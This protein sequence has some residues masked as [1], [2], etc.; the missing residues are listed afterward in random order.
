MDMTIFRNLCILAAC[1]V[2]SA[3]DQPSR[4]A[5][6][7]LP[8]E[9][10]AAPESDL[11]V[12]VSFNE[13]IQPLLSEYCYH[14]H[15]PDSGTRE[16]KDHPLRLDRPEDAFVLR[17]NGLPAIIKGKP[18]ESEV[19]KRM[20]LTDP[21]MIM[22]PP[23]SHKT[24]K[25][26]E[27]ALIERWIE[28]GAEFEP[29]WAFVPVKKPE[30]PT[31]GADWAANPID[32]FVAEKL[33][34]HGM[35]PNPPEDPRRFYRRLHLDLTGL[36]PT[37]EA[38]EAFVKASSADFQ[39]AVEKAADELLV[40]TA[41]A[42]NFTRHWLDAARY[43]DTHGI[44]I[45]NYRAIWPY[46]DWVISAF[47]NNMPWDQFTLEQIA[48]DMLPDRT[49]DQ[50]VATGFSRCL[51][52][53]GEGGA[54]A[55]EYDAIYAKDRVETVSAVWLGLTTGCAAC[56]DHKFDPVSTKEFYS[57]TAF[58]R[59]TPM[60][61]LDN[62]NAKHPPNVFVP[63][64]P[65]RERWTALLAEISNVEKRL[66]EREKSS[67]LDFETWL[68]NASITPERKIDSTLHLHLPL[69]ESDGPLRGFVDGQAREWSFAA[70]RVDA[71]FG[72]AP[73]ISMSPVELGD[74]ANFSCGEPVTFGGFIRVEGTP[75]GAVIARMD[76][77][78]SLRG[79]DLYLE[80]GKPASHVIDSWDKAANKIVAKKPLVPGQ[81]HH[82]MITFDGTKSGHQT[83]AIY[84]DGKL[85]ETQTSP[86]SVGGNIEAQVPLRL[87]S[88]Q[89]GDS[90]LD[91]EVA[92][93]DL[94]FYRRLL[95]DR[96]IA[97]ISAS[98]MLQQ[99]VATPLA[100][101]TED[102][103]KLIH[104]YFLANIDTPSREIFTQLDTLHTEQRELRARG[105]MTLVMEEKKAE[106]YAHVLTRGVYTDKGEKVTPDTPAVMRRKTV[107]ASRAGSTIPPTPFPP[108]SR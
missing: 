102:Q 68:V 19:V 52:T 83:S 43:A 37:P 85:A 64:L 27:I 81:W 5:A 65:D 88:R 107:S 40:T 87:G 16:P 12:T 75:T 1:L 41:S 77:S 104:Q 97:A 67:H 44:H 48:G 30:L 69:T 92:I 79:W 103:R 91:G 45:D 86:N 106:P 90:A 82:V 26:E 7:T 62:N 71:P 22:P 29:H 3:C 74:I 96:E 9:E 51:P 15:G 78:E 84:L 66:V 59:N 42:E 32:R 99:A 14:C 38:V 89:G 46:R 47:K 94:R 6:A 23:K 18:A 10:A 57:L 108:A 39:N 56:H 49:L 34:A 24:M 105:S 80:N 13:H 36:P 33:E 60:T 58:F 2:L 50:L 53:T 17:D 20:H 72:K 76:P 55:E 100:Q 101:L 93:Q 63:L 31:S 21:E 4:Q 95:H 8:F 98:S 70:E 11:P 28:Q 54:I 61:A 35:K 25:P 73:V